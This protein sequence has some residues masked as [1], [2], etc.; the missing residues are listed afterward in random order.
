MK[1]HQQFDTSDCGA[2]CIA[3]I[4]SYFGMNLNLEKTREIIGT[5]S[6]GT[7]LKGFLN[8]A[9]TYNMKCRIVQGN[10]GFN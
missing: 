8:A 7:N 3:M 9:N 6:E 10:T 4:A 2:A 5:D 1:Y